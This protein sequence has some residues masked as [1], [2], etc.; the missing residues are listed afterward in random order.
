MAPF[1]MALSD[2]RSHLPIVGL[3]KCD[4]LYSCAASYKILTDTWSLCD[5]K[6]S[7]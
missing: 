3:F 4:F 1:Q 2:R 5:G 6:A 7:S